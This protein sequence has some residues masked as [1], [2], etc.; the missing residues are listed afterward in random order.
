MLTGLTA[1]IHV[2]YQWFLVVSRSKSNILNVTKQQTISR[3][4]VGVEYQ[5]LA[6][7][8]VELQFVVS[9]LVTLLF[10]TLN[11]TYIA[12]NPIFHVVSILS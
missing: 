11:T 12:S 7:V 10:D 8:N 9:M 6:H 2:G 3:Y 5:F 1:K 4:S